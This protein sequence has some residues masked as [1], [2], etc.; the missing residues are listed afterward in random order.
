VTVYFADSSFSALVMSFAIE[1]SDRA[2]VH[3]TA[4]SK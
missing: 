1:Q 2:T 4:A 3:L